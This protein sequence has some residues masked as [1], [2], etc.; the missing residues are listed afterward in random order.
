M[1][2]CV[3]GCLHRTIAG[4]V[5]ELLPMMHYALLSYSRPIARL[6]LDH[7]YELFAKSDLRFVEEAMKVARSL[8]STRPE[9]NPAQFLASGY[10]ERK[11]Q[12]VC[13]LLKSV[14]SKEQEL[15]GHRPT[16]RK[17]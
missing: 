12:F 11:L 17:G 14:L 15:Q 9:L 3:H 4:D 2:C 16:F 6:L 1:L 5:R 8:F 7:G 13:K 10:A